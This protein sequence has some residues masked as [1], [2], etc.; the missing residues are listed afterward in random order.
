MVGLGVSHTEVRAR[1]APSQA[2]GRW[3]LIVRVPRWAG[4]SL[5]SFVVRMVGV[6]CGVGYYFML[7]L[8]PPPSSAYTVSRI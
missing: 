4:S 2:G 5:I 7:K 3:S 8:G 6:V 1:Q